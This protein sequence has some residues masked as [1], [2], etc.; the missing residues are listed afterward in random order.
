[1]YD[2]YP[3]KE[4]LSN[5]DYKNTLLSLSQ[6]TEQFDRNYYF[7]RLYNNHAIYY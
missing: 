7:S 2:K 1:M 5:D 3:E 4:N 6:A